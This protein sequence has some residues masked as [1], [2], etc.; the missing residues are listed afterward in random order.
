[1]AEPFLPLFAF[2]HVDH[3]VAIGKRQAARGLGAGSGPEQ[4]G[5]TSGAESDGKAWSSKDWSHGSCSHRAV[6]LGAG[7]E[8]N[9]RAIEASLSQIVEAYISDYLDGSQWTGANCRRVEH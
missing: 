7:A 2:R 4:S 8:D 9:R 5:A 3:R 1:M 6:R